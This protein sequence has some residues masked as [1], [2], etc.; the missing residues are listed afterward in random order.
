MQFR[1]LVIKYAI[2]ISLVLC[3]FSEGINAQS[4]IFQG[5]YVIA[6]PGDTILVEYQIKN[7]PGI[8]AYQMDFYF[9]RE[10]LE[11]TEVHQGLSGLFMSNPSF[12]SGGKTYLRVVFARA[13]EIKQD[14]L[15]FSFS[16]KVSNVAPQSF[17]LTIQTSNILFYSED[18]QEITYEMKQARIF[19]EKTST[20]ESSSILS[21]SVESVYSETSTVSQID[22]LYFKESEKDSSTKISSE[23]TSYSSE[24]DKLSYG[25]IISDNNS[26]DSMMEY[27]LNP[28]KV[29]NNGTFGITYIWLILGLSIPIIA[30]STWF[31][32][33]RNK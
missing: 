32:L 15:L 19:K 25:N 17:D 10:I 30:L 24:T 31:I 8:A 33:I 21:A 7:N 27:S 13:D 16:M 20:D 4:I 5:S 18:G 28:S 2:G 23:E 11:L 26:R 22:S 6:N 12:I 29:E 1:H 3:L 9:D 14:G